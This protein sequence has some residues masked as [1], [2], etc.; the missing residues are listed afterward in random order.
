VQRKHA[1]GLWAC[2][3]LGFVAGGA[4]AAGCSDKPEALQ[5]DDGSVCRDSDCD[6]ICDFDEGID[7]KRDTDGDGAPDFLDSDSDGDGMTDRDEAGDEDRLSPPADRD[8]NGLLDYLDPKYPLHYRPREPDAGTTR[9]KDASQEGALEPETMGPP[10]EPEPTEPSE[11][12]RVE[13][14]QSYCSDDERGAAECDGIDNDCDGRVDNDARCACERGAA[15]SCFRGPAGRRNVGACTS[16]IQR[17]VGVEFSYWGPCEDSVAPSVERCDGVDNDCNGCADELNHCKPSLSCP[18]LD[19]LRVPSAL[20]FVPYLLDAK[21]FYTGPE[22]IS[23][24]FAIRGSPCDRMFSRIDPLADA[25]SGTQSFELLDPHAAQTHVV[26]SLSGS[27]TVDLTVVT[28]AGELRCSFVVHVRGPGLRV[29][30]CWDKTGPSAQRRGDAVDLDLHLGKLGVTQ[31]FESEADC[32]WQTCRGATGP[33]GYPDTR[34]LGGCTGPTAQN[35]AAYSQL[36]FC[37]NPR[38]DADNR[39]DARSRAVYITENVNLDVPVPGDRFRIAVLYKANVLSDIQTGDA[40]AATS[41]DAR[42]WVNVYCGGDL[43]GTFGGDPEQ[44]LDPDAIRL[45]APG[46][47]WR[48]ADVAVSS[49][50]CEISALRDPLT[51]QGYWI[52]NHDFSYGEP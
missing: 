39:L 42:A 46:M 8:R 41:I 14:P 23:Y 47:L 24:H 26:F 27:Y 4:L 10:P 20:P 12:C 11:L 18:G 22:A 40:G 5:C 16:G 28:K 34:E 48:V 2:C 37:P 15:R 36:G 35:F 45:S 50:G 51:Q 19:D 30:L 9:D 25:V 33:W 21:R 1:F 32:Y 17:C 38:L 44:Q 3:F 29:E 43:L 6:F 49:A 31:Q 7:A 52:T 13:L